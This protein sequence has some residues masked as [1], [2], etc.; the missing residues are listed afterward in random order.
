MKRSLAAGSNS[1]ALPVGCDTFAGPQNPQDQA[2]IHSLGQ[3]K[4][5]TAEGETFFVVYLSE[6]LTSM[7]KSETRP[8]DVTQKMTKDCSVY[9][10]A[11]TPN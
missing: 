8:E 9:F 3:G 6:N 5:L 7:K 10:G 2:R 11:K 1:L 4:G